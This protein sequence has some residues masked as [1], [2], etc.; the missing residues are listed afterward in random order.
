MDHIF[1]SYQRANEKEA[2]ELAAR[3]RSEQIN[4]WQDLSGE[5]YG[6]PYSVKWWEAIEEALYNALCAIIIRTEKWEKSSPCSKECELIVNNQIPAMQIAEE[7]FSDLDQLVARIKQWYGKEVLANDNKQRAYLFSQA[8]RYG[9]DRKIS[10]LLP[11]KIGILEAITQ[12]HDYASLSEYA[13]DPSFASGNPKAKANMFA[14]LRKAKRKLLCEQMIKLFMFALGIVGLVL[15]CIVIAALPHIIR[16]SNGADYTAKANAAI[17]LIRDISE[18]DPIASISLLSNDPS[19]QYLDVQASF[20]FIQPL[21][22]ELLDKKYPCD[23]FPAGSD[24]ALAVQQLETADVPVAYNA[25]TGAFTLDCGGRSVTLMLDCAP[26]TYCYARERNE[27]LVAADNLILVYDMDGAM[28]AIPLVYNFETLSKVLYK[29]D[30][31]FGITDSGNVVCWDDPIQ[32]KAF[33]YSLSEGT[34]LKNGSAAYLLGG[35]LVIQTDKREEAIH[36]PYNDISAFAFSTDEKYAAVASQDHDS[37]NRMLVIDLESKS[38][39][40]DHEI[41]CTIWS[42]AFAKEDGYLFAAGYDAVLRYQWHTGTVAAS[43]AAGGFYSVIAY[44]DHVV[45]STVDGLVAEFDADLRQITNWAEIV[46]GL[47]PPKQLAVSDSNGAVFAANRGGNTIGG[48]RRV[49]LSNG[50]IYRIALE[51]ESGLLSNTS[52]S[53]SDDGEFVAFGYPNGKV[54]VWSVDTLNLLYSN[55]TVAEQI[56]AVRF[57]DDCLYGFG[58]SGTVYRF[59]FQGL[60]QMIDANTVYSYWNDYLKAAAKI[61]Q[62]M[63]EL[64]LTYISP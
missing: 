21:M 2:S 63:Y 16:S 5:E 52:V 28:Q 20:R 64:K 4:V 32:R 33:S 55:W 9:K 23:F 6:I 43:N 15:L 25:E 29:D 62:R 14:F 58:K 46:P 19:A 56:I 1:I 39:I 37:G 30:R 24:D 11:G 47:V 12:Y 48:C 61:H 3:L 34:L 51:A 18:Y 49:K 42:I 45:V 10:H 59:D 57:G 17:D 60:V 13:R 40:A 54:T 8:Y 41:P 7:E 27:L 26:T 44:R 50:S 36:L 35:D 53:V 38:I 22:C 31:I